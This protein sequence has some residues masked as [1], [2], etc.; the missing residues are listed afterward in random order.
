MDAAGPATDDSGLSSDEML[1]RLRALS[2]RWHELAKYL[3][4]L[5]RAGIDG[6]A[7]EEATGLERKIQ[8]VWSTAAQ[9]RVARGQGGRKWRAAVGW[10]AAAWLRCTAAITCWSASILCC[11]A[12]LCSA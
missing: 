7:V 3:P 10:F 4:A 12:G 5:Q 8:N 2:G 11:C 6:M 1:G 9:V